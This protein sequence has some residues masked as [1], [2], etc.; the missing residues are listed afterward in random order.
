[1]LGRAVRDL[2]PIRPAITAAEAWQL[3]L[4]T[5]HTSGA[6][7]T[8]NRIID[9]FPTDQQE[10]IRVQLANTMIA[11]L[12]QTLC[13]RIDTEGRLASYEFMYVTA[14]IQ[15]LIRENKV[16]RIDSQIQT[17]KRYGMQLL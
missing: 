14:G 17:G 11:V 5:L 12:S 3:G 6:A 1:M 8:I 9:A 13:P 15:S 16:F 4:A 7:P 10:Q 2:A